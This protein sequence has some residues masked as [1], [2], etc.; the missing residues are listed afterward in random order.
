M[1]LYH[2]C[3]HT[4]CYSVSRFEF[5]SPKLLFYLILLKHFVHASPS[6]HATPSI[7]Y[8]CWLFSDYPIVSYSGECQDKSDFHDAKLR[9]SVFSSLQTTVRYMKF[10]I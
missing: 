7:C 1:F 2:Q 6:S 5:S 8:Y 4:K 9:L 10:M 3:Y